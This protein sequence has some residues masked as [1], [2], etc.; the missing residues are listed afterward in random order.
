MSE[1]HTMS[2]TIVRNHTMPR[3]RHSRPRSF[4]SLP[5]SRSLHPL[6]LFNL[7]PH[8]S[9]ILSASHHPLKF[10]SPSSPFSSLLSLPPLLVLPSLTW[11]TFPLP[12][13][14]ELR[15]QTHFEVG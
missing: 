11:S 15:N 8:S 2:Y 12:G 7:S 5:S 9:L 14:R 3:K 1:G 4:G 10:F 13:T 6:F